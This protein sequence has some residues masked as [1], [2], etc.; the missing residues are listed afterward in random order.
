MDTE[1]QTL[2]ELKAARSELDRL[3]RELVLL[4]QVAGLVVTNTDEKW[5]PQD[6][7]D[8]IDTILGEM[9]QL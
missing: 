9:E 3:Y 5:R 4:R 6:L 1:T 2:K 7:V 8:R